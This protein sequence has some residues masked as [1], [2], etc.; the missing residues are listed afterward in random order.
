MYEI[1]V[2]AIRKTRRLQYVLHT[3]FIILSDFKKA[4]SI[5]SVETKCPDTALQC[6]CRL[7]GLQSIA[8]NWKAEGH[9]TAHP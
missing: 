5:I 7:L 1:E 4:T 6:D 3:I 9:H 8:Y 2:I